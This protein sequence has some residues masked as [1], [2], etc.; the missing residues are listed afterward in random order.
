MIELRKKYPALASDGNFEPIY[1]ESGKLPFI[2]RRSSEKYFYVIAVN[3][4]SSSLVHHLDYDI[5]GDC[6]EILLTLN[7][8]IERIESDWILKMGGVSSIIIKVL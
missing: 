4:S 6:P 7:S 1:A 3:P 8:S 2:F 5:L